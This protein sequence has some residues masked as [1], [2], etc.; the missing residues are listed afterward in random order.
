MTQRVGFIGLGSMGLG[1]SS[2]LATAGFEVHGYDIDAAKMDQLAARGTRFTAGITSNVVCQP[3]RA[4]I[5]SDCS[6]VPESVNKDY[7]HPTVVF[8]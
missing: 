3:T 4:S 6:S 7:L 1:M 8:Y 5:R 2:N